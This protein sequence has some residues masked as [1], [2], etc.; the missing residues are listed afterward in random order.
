MAV[1]H[2]YECDSC[3]ALVEDLPLQKKSHRCPKCKKGTLQIIFR[4]L[5]AR[6]ASALDS[7]S[8][9]V[10][11][12][13]PRTGKVAYPGRNDVPM[14]ARYQQQGYVR[15]ELRS[16]RELDRFSERHGLVNEAAHYNSGNGYDSEPGRR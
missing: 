6:N 5:L 7:H 15:K 4:S 8:M 11:Y 9:T 14:P 12:E 16:L 13:D 2:D 10:V 3:G 1:L